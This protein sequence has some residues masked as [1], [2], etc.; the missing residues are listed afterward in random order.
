MLLSYLDKDNE[1]VLHVVIILVETNLP[2]PK[3]GCGYHLWYAKGST[4]LSICHSVAA[5]LA[6]TG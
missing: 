1:M 6:I 4:I 3:V 5:A 2:G